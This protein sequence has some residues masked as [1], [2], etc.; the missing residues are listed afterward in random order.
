MSSRI[1]PGEFIAIMINTGGLR[2]YKE[3][4]DLISEKIKRASY[5][6]EHASEHEQAL[7]KHNY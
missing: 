2:L 3:W 7:Q 1:E 6:D 4:R 5:F